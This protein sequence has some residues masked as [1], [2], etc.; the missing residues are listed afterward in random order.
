MLS[1]DTI[2]E[3]YTIRGTSH[4]ERGTIVFVGGMACPRVVNNIHTR[5]L[6][7]KFRTISVDLPGS[8]TLSG[9]QFSVARSVRV[10]KRVVDNEVSAAEQQL[11]VILVGYGAGNHVVVSA[12]KQYPEI[13]SG[14]VIAGNL[15]EHSCVG[16]CRI[17]SCAAQLLREAWV[18]EIFDWQY[19]SILEDCN[20]IATSRVPQ[21][22][23]WDTAPEWIRE[24]QGMSL[25]RRLSNL[26]QKVLAITCRSQDLSDLAVETSVSTALV[27]G[28]DGDILP[29]CDN[30]TLSQMRAAIEKFANA[31]I[32]D[33]S[34][35]S[36]VERGFSEAGGESSFS[37][38]EMAM[39]VDR[40][41]VEGEATKSSYS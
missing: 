37:G 38:D 33:N 39:Y 24:I 29:S 32:L 10:L 23:H 8:G 9:V 28:V 41:D 27:D 40:D 17:G 3:H 31:A 11:S 16:C 14:V 4:I 6:S 34:A 25:L 2:F 12:C 7:K 36:F 13:C 30:E 19:D 18:A 21:R 26:K 15:R 5:D 20:R 1:G 35:F 22:F